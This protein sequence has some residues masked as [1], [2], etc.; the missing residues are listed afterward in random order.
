MKSPGQPVRIVADFHL[1]V[2]QIFEKQSFQG[3]A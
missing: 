1:D 3:V 2:R